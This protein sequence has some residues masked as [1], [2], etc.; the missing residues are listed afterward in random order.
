M[1]GKSDTRQKMI[2]MMYLVFIAM[3]ALNISKEVL[4]TLGILNDDLES[5]IEE[6]ESSSKISYDQI[7][8]NSDNLDYKI[9]AEMVGDLKSV[10]DDLY[11]FIQSIK[12]SLVNSDENRFLKEVSV[13]SNKDS[14]ITM[15]DYQ[16]MDKSQT[17]DEYFFQGDTYT[18]NGELFLSKFINYPFLV[19]EILSEITLKEEESEKETKIN[20][21]FGSISNEID[22]RFKYSDK[23][24]T[25]EGTESPFLNYNFQGFPMIASISKLTKIQS[26]IRYIENKILSQILNAVQNK[27]LNF[28]TFQT[29]LETT[30]PVYYTTDVIDAAVVMG[31]KDEGFRPDKVELFINGNPLKSSE[32]KI[33]RG[34][35]VLNK[36]ISSPGTYELTGTITKR[37]ADT[38]ELVSIPVS[39]NIVI[40][41][42]PNS[43]VVSAD[44]MKVFY[45]GLRNPSS[46]SI[47]GVAESSIIPS[48]NNGQFIK[49]TNG[50]WGAV[51]TSDF[52]KKTM[53]V[54]VSGILNGVRKNFD[55]GEFRI[56]EPPPGLGS[57]KVNDN[58]YKPTEN[59]PKRYLANGMITGNKPKDFLYDFVI[60]VTSFDIKV[61]NSPSKS[62]I[63][64]TARNNPKAVDDINS[65][66]RG[67]VV[68]IS[69]IKASAKDGDFVNPNYIVNDFIVILE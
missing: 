28:N 53:K 48:S 10:S 61:G 19:K 13:K 58:Y 4:A 44:N 24:V 37:N 9:A 45:R 20:Y 21:D 38:Q 57:I 29:L 3:L 12:D 54:S 52:S 2:N 22:N 5:S 55:G 39:Q 8:S 62:V 50:G 67:T 59:I 26:D 15:M 6:F 56:L 65:Q 40:I 34:K 43:A 51:P 63:G 41:K 16:I 23:V 42:E 35:V 69:N 49:L 18:K 25:S 17:L 11:G 64:N 27:G 47:P 14:I 33:E 46:I 36:K 60:E 7:N 68:R 30:K 66:G 1:A 32:F 31:K